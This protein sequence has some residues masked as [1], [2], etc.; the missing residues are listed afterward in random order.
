M[1]I[2]HNKNAKNKNRNTN[3]KKITATVL[4]LLMVLSLCACDNGK[5]DKT[6]STGSDLTWE[7]IEK[8][9]EKELKKEG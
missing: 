7:Q 9:A 6:P 1:E 4:L 3:M 2:G 5:N 8:M